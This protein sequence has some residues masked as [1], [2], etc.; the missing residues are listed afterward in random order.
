MNIS[1]CCVGGG[2]PTLDSSGASESS[3]LKDASENSN[4]TE[5]DILDTISEFVDTIA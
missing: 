5:E 4:P 2:F 1:S 3:A